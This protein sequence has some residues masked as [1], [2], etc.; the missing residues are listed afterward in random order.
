MEGSGDEKVLTVNDELPPFESQ[1]HWS[2]AVTT[3]KLDV[4]FFI[5]MHFCQGNISS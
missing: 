2:C 3:F 1:D 5:H 4:Q